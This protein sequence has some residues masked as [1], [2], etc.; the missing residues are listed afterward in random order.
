MTVTGGRGDTPLGRFN[1]LK[2]AVTWSDV[3]G[4]PVR[5]SLQ[6]AA[7]VGQSADGSYL[8]GRLRQSIRYQRKTTGGGVQVQFISGVPYAQYV[9]DGTKP[10]VIRANAARALRIPLRGGGVIFRAQVYH[11]GTQ[12]NP[13]P[14]RVLV[15][16]EPFVQR[17]LR[18]LMSG[19]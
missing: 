13:F 2:A 14:R 18:D 9:I 16:M 15:E 12:P 11:P 1:F 7:P 6:R 17:T 5:T 10:H 19:G 8:G 4:P 3:I